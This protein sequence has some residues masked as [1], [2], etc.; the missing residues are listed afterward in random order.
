[1]RS[2]SL[3]YNVS[4]LKG[5]Y[6]QLAYHYSVVMQIVCAACIQS[7]LRFCSCTDYFS[8]LQN[9]FGYC[10]AVIRKCWWP[11]HYF[12]QKN[13]NQESPNIYFI[14]FKHNMVCISDVCFFF[15]ALF[16]TPS[17]W[18]STANCSFP[19]LHRLYY[20]SQLLL[21]LPSN[22]QYFIV[23]LGCWAEVSF[24][25]HHASLCSYACVYTCVSE[26]CC[27]RSSVKYLSFL[28]RL[29]N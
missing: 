3:R 16:P 19:W 23:Q 15:R 27:W 22:I 8:F 29:I 2:V 28:G 1:M 20:N 10:L 9:D 26:M 12:F 4:A 18:T 25:S 21:L 24:S 17:L 6:F 14:F 5:T 11:G 7:S 13:Q